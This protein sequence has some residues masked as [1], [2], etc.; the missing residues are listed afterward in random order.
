MEGRCIAFPNIYQHRVSPFE[1]RDKSKPGH[2][3]IL[4]FFLVDPTLGQPRPVVPNP[5]PREKKNFW[6]NGKD[7]GGSSRSGNWVQ[8]GIEKALNFFT[9]RPGAAGELNAPN[10]TAIQP[11]IPST[12]VIPP[13][14]KH[15]VSLATAD[16]DTQLNN[17][18]TTPSIQVQTA[19]ASLSTIMARP[20]GENISALM[21]MQDALEY[22]LELMDERTV[23]VG[24]QD[25]QYFAT[26][27]NFCEH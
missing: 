3:K 16:I 4:A 24:T 19:N 1:L 11:K 8:D 22:R 23:F 9:S 10:S 14:Q 27:F 6:G 15:W 20:G 18:S 21:T 26:T 5:Q 12:S 2:R 13:Q 17:S 7:E 25:E